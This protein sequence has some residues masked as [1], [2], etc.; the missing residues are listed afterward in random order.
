[1]PTS[2]CWGGRHSSIVR[3]ARKKAVGTDW[4]SAQV[5]LCRRPP[6]A[7]Q[8][9]SAQDYM[10]RRHKAI[11]GTSGCQGLVNG[12]NLCR[13]P[14][15]GTLCR[16]LGYRHRCIFCIYANLF[17]ICKYLNLFIYNYSRIFIPIAEIRTP[18]RNCVKSHACAYYLGGWECPHNVFVSTCCVQKVL[19]DQNLKPRVCM[20]HVC[21]CVN[22]VYSE[23]LAHCT[24]TV[25]PLDFSGRRQAGR[26]ECSIGFG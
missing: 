26:L 25:Y 9:P 6:S 4:P 15:S 24:R 14:H 2:F 8:R 20:L 22:R 11:V 18:L 7:H 5:Q 10:G 3:Q 1:M 12:V 21:T 17:I 19:L 13:R 16:R 23:T